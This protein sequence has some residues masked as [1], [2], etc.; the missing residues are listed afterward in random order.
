[1]ENEFVDIF[2][3]IKE[4]RVIFEDQ[5]KVKNLNLETDLHESMPQFIYADPKRLKQILMNLV[6][7]ALKFTRQGKISI[8]LEML[9]NTET[10]KKGLP[11]VSAYSKPIEHDFD[12]QHEKIL[13]RKLYIEVEDTGVGMQAKDLNKLFKLFG[14]L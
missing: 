8:S 11:L 12:E 7:N 14:K 13:Y 2:K 9:E 1:M 3:L 6:S 4:L 10:V 5:C